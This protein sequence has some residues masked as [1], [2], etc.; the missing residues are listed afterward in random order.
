MDAE[1]VADKA[2]RAISDFCINDCRA[3]CCRKGYLT[4]G[5]DSVKAVTQGRI[6]A[7][8]EI[9]GKY[10]MHL[11]SGC[12]SLKDFKCLIHK[13]P[14]RPL[15]C[16]Q[17]PIFLEGKTVRLSPRCLAVK[18]NLLYPYVAKLVKMGY[19]IGENNPYAEMEL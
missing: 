7:L 8:K 12:P 6:V 16:R 13:N 4:F 18:N 15:A 19:K 10:S 2:R 5:K 17:F 1:R 9:N 11:G 14:K 3:Y